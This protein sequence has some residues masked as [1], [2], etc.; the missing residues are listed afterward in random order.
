MQNKEVTNKN[1]IQELEE[2]NNNLKEK[3]EKNEKTIAEKEKLINDLN[4]KKE[5]FEAVING[6]DEKLNM[7]KNLGISN[8]IL[9]PISSAVPNDPRTNIIISNDKL[10]SIFTN[11]L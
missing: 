10:N 7:L 3:N 9:A 2:E 5:L 1:K 8:E 4:Q 11:F 6:N